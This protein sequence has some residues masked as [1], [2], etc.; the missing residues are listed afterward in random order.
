MDEFFQPFVAYLRGGIGFSSKFRISVCTSR[1]MQLCAESKKQITEI[2]ERKYYKS[3]KK[4]W[5]KYKYRYNNSISLMFVY[6]M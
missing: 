4:I 6:S 2:I 1:G 5:L 3:N